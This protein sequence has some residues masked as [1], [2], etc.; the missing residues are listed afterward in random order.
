MEEQRP[1]YSL[2]AD[3]E[4]Y[5]KPKRKKRGL[6]KK[7]KT[8]LGVAQGRRSVARRRPAEA[9]SAAA[10]ASAISPKQLRSFF[11]FLFFF[12]GCFFFFFVLILWSL[13]EEL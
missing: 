6:R 8:A 9:V 1:D 7:D 4:L 5:Q 11:F 2:P 3:D 12:V 13:A 10:A